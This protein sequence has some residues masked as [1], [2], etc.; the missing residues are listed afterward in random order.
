[1]NLLTQEL[2]YHTKTT[3][4]LY[5]L[6]FGGDC[7]CYMEYVVW[8]SG[9]CLNSRGFKDMELLHSKEAPV[10]WN[11]QTDKNVGALIF[12]LNIEVAGRKKLNAVNS[13]PCGI[14]GP[15]AATY[16]AYR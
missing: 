6:Q 2:G 13:G 5:R 10:K 11:P 9:R 8:L 12:K 4:I 15:H 7:A 14:S 16:S 1:M 3:K